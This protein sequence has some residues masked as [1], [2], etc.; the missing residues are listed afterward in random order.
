M[1]Q[2][3]QQVKRFSA[4]LAVWAYRLSLVMLLGLMTY[5]ISRPEYNYAHWIPHNILQRL[6][7][8]YENLLWIEQNGDYFLHFIGALLLTT[9]IFAARLPWSRD[10]AWR[11]GLIVVLMCVGAE[12]LQFWIGRG[13]DSSDLLFGILGS[14]MAYLAINKNKKG[15]SE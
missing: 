5:V 15:R 14:F 4:K 6:G 9:L 10:A 7:A 3:N 8:S 2:S 1:N 12:A 13:I 11:S